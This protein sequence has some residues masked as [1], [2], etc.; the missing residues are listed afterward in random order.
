MKQK[1][2]IRLL[3]FGLSAV[4][5]LSGCSG[6]GK[7]DPS[8][9][10]SNTPSASVPAEDA[11]KD[12]S[13]Y[14]AYLKLSSEL[15]KANDILNLYFTHV[16]YTKEF[17]LA[18]GGNYGEMKNEVSSYISNTFYVQQAL[19]YVDKEPSYPAVDAAVRALGDSPIN[20]MKAI[21]KLG[22]YLRFDD[23]EKDNMAQ[24]AELHAALWEPLQIFDEYYG[25]FIKAIDDLAE[26][27][28]DEDLEDLK[29]NG[30]MILY[31]SRIMMRSSEN[32]LNNILD[33]VR[34]ANTDTPQDADLIVPE[35]DKTELAPLF[36]E[37]NNAYEAL[38]AAMDKDEEKEKVFTGPLADSTIKLYTS[39]VNTHFVKMGELAK[40][41]NENGDYIDAWQNAQE[42]LSSMIKGYNS[43]I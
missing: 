20:V 34:A 42:S 19:D 14:N 39:K 1:N 9:N 22:S 40:V 29:Q 26:E 11:P 7:T 18:E 23:F 10:P 17:A 32:I 43:I 37:L 36:L 21:D 31:H 16:E 33:Q 30:E 4:L 15:D 8:S 2:L 41:L 28:E 5:L 3:A 13:K 6:E 27:T 24:A 12:Y 35:L 25:S 38:T